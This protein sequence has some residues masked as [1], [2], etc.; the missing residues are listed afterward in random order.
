MRVQP[1]GLRRVSLPENYLLLAFFLGGMVQ[2]GIY[3][4]CHTGFSNRATAFDQLL[5]SALVAYWV[6]LDSARRGIPRSS[7]YGY[8]VFAF[9]PIL[10]PWH[11]FKTRGW[12]GFITIGIF[13]ALCVLAFGVPYIF[14]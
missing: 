13:I 7:I 4:Y 6:V 11:I 1:R 9:S 5:L 12:K 14:S 10:A 2:T 8:L 3:A